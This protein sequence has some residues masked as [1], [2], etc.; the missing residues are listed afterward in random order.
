MF[1]NNC[2]F[3]NS[4]QPL[5]RL[6]DCKRPSK[7]STQCKCTVTPIGWQFFVQPIAAKCCRGRGG[8]LSRILGKNTISNEHPVDILCIFFLISAGYLQILFTDIF[9]LKIPIFIE[10]TS[11]DAFFNTMYVCRCTMCMVEEIGI[12]LNQ[13]EKKHE[14]ENNIWRSWLSG[15]DKSTNFQ[16]HL[17]IR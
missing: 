14:S 4:L 6:H 11:A 16:S 12:H 5:P 3:H 7:L 10:A 2:V 1:R 8:K 15:L 13:R 17:M 9:L